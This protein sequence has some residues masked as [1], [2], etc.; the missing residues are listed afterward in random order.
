MLFKSMW[1]PANTDEEYREKLKHRMHFIPVLV[2]AGAA[3]IV[4]SSVLLWSGE[5]KDSFMAGLY[6]GMG[7]GVLA[8]S[9][10]WF[11]KIRS[12]LQDEKKLRMKRLKESDERNIQI[13]LK[14][15]YTAGLLLIAAGYVTMLISG[16]FSMEVFWTV[17]TLVMLYFVLFLAGK[18]IYE[19]RM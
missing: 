7:C 13:A 9:V 11:L 5:E 17:W 12:T 2:I 1:V 6:M 19:K 14:A 16:F 3:A 4:V 8:V 18:V 15:H 10:V